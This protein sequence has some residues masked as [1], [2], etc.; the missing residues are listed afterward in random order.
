MLLIAATAFAQAITLIG[1]IPALIGTDYGRVSLAKLVLF[2]LMLC[3]ALWNRLSLTDRLDA[4]DAARSRKLLVLSIATET[5]CGLLVVLTAGLLASLVPGEHQQVL[6]PFSQRPSLAVLADPDLRAEVAL[7]FLA[8]GIGIAAVV[9]SFNA[10]RFRIP[11]MVAAIALIAWHAPSLSQ[12][13]VEAYPT[14]YQT[15]ATGFTA[16]S[17]ARGQAVFAADCASC[18]GA[19]GQGN[20]PSAAGMR[21]KPA[22]LTAAHLWDHADGDL[23][24]WIGHGIEAPN[25]GLAMPAFLAILTDDDLWAAIDFVRALNAGAA[26]QLSG[27]WTY[28]IPA[29]DLP[30]VCAHQQADRLR[31]LRGRFVRITTTDAKA[32]AAGDTAILRLDRAIDRPAPA[33][34]CASASADAWGAFAAVAG[35]TPDA[36]AGSEFL[37]DPRGWLRAAKSG[38]QGPNW[39]DPVVLNDALRQLREHPISA[40]LGGIHVHEH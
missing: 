25:G 26:F 17:I 4:A 10:R 33:N 1:G 6:W 18:H 40:T 39:N 19:G 27:A 20:G 12:L 30:I 37:I 11:T 2:L 35:V 24:W 28:P 34:A 9:V 3:L 7:A 5:G 32:M 13:L 15:S 16:A 38:D 31:D 36:L 23:F 14:S 22:D 29:P 8:I 21:V